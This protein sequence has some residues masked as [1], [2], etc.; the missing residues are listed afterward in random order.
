MMIASYFRLGTA[1]SCLPWL[2]PMWKSERTNRA[3]GADQSPL[4]RTH[5][6]SRAAFMENAI[7]DE[8]RRFVCGNCSWRAADSI[9]AGTQRGLPVPI[10]TALHERTFPLCDSLNYREWSGYYTVSVYETHHEHEYNAIRNA[11]ALIDISP[12]YKYRVTGSD[13]TRFVNRVNVRDIN[14]VAVGQVIYTCW[15]DEQGK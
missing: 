2:K 3:A 1:D 10:G 14:K 8:S 15:C 11:A 13:A 12:L 4:G 5:H 6:A 9:I 7:L